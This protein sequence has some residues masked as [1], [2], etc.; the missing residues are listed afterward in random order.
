MITLWVLQFGRKGEGVIMEKKLSKKV[1]NLS[2]FGD[3]GFTLFVDVELYY[4]SAFLTD[5]AKFSLAMVGFILTLTSI[6]DCIWVPVTGWLIEKCNFKWGKY[7][8]WLLIGPPIMIF[9]YALEF[10][11]ISSSM[12]LAAGIVIVGF[13]VKTLAQDLAYSASVSLVSD[14]SNDPKERM[15]LAA[16][17]GMFLSLGNVVFA[18]IALPIITFMSKVTGST[19]LGYTTAAILF[20]IMNY[21]CYL[22]PF[23]V[24]KGISV[25]GNGGAEDA[26]ADA[27]AKEK[28][29]TGEMIKAVFTNPPLLALICGDAFRYLSNFLMAAV[30]F[31][32][33]VVVLGN[34]PAM[35]LYLTVTRFAGLVGSI[36]ANPIAQR[37]GKRT[38]YLGSCILMALGLVACYLFGNTLG[39]FIVIQI[40]VNFFMQI[41][42]STLTAM[43][44]DTV[45]YYEWK[46]G[47]DARGFIMSM[48]NVP[49][50]IGALLR[51]VVLSAGLAAAGYVADQAV[52]TTETI[53]GVSAVMNLYPAAFLAAC[54][55]IVALGYRLSDQK[56]HQMTE[57]IATRKGK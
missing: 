54:T 29:S 48:L 47:K 40:I 10:S 20:G 7:R 30:G 44:T 12:A 8:S 1:L 38:S 14:L 4:W 35:T 37:L 41:S 16:R 43:F 25:S 33:F 52:Y 3:F 34:L 49:I 13:S 27:S 39:T 2:G 53:K 5:Y 51:G 17:R 9:A 31:Y 18:I 28:L 56:I 26:S 22:V 24:T 42:M 45:V 11:R 15:T 55:V 36:F 46:T 19:V 57:E 50:K 21:V 23:F 32:Y 6:I